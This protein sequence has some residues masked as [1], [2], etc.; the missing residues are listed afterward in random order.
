MFQKHGFQPAFAGVTHEDKHA[1]MSASNR[2]ESISFNSSETDD[3]NSFSS[4]S[5]KG[6]RRPAKKPS[7]P[8]H[9]KQKKTVTFEINGRDILKI[10]AILAALILIA[11]LGVSAI[12]SM[13]KPKDIRYKDNAFASYQAVDGT[14]RVSMNGKVLKDVF[15]SEV[16]LTAAKD[17]SFAY[18][19]ATVSEA[20]NVYI[21]DNG[22]L[23]LFC[24][25]LDSVL[26]YSELEPGVIYTR[27]GRVE[28][29]Y[30]DAI[31]SLSR[32]GDN[33]PQNFVI[34]PDGTAVAYTV[35]NKNDSSIHDLYV[36]TVDMASPESRSTGTV[37]TIP[38]SIANG[39]SDLLAYITDGET[40]YL[41]HIA[42]TMR[43]R[44]NDLVGSFNAVTATNSTGTETVFTT[45]AGTE[46]YSYIYDFEMLDKEANTA[47][48]FGPGY[49]IPQTVDS[50]VVYKA[51]FKKSYFQNLTSKVTFYV[52]RKYAPEAISAY[53]G[54]FS[55]D[56]KY[57]YCINEDKEALIRYDLAT[58][59]ARS[60]S[61]DVTDFVITQKGNIYYTD[62]YG[63]LKFF[64]LSKEKHV[65]IAS[66]VTKFTFYEDSNE[67]YFERAGS[68]ESTEVYVT[69][70]G[71]DA[72]RVLFGKTELTE[73]PTFTN[74]YSKKSYAY[75]YD[76]EKDSM[77]LYYT[78]TGGSFKII[79]ECTEITSDYLTD[80]EKLIKDVL[81]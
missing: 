2:Y 39:G 51:T 53:L 72:E 50:E 8:P 73:L 43:H 14:Y 17:N 75:A 6:A 44:I 70:E 41:Y 59:E 9:K 40:K 64:K 11:V 62:G 68:V 69:S 3:F 66:D 71:S 37:S 45:K 67:L 10:V 12:I 22:K 36:Y 74:K 79:A 63:D 18:V 65:R 58:D 21:L 19:T 57:F 16:V 78:S 31:T 81:S 56:M 7:R 30:D 28:Y 32:S 24:E 35:K 15:E 76:K 29:F 46:Y 54:Q 20:V 80:I 55:P 52:D 25:G 34:S 5:S 33:T 27:R 49:S 13:G 38:V 42:G 60:V 47:V 4:S 48:Y 26:K 23:T 77:I 61:S 1:K